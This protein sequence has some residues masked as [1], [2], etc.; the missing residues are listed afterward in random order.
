[1][2]QRYILNLAAN[3]A[4]IMANVKTRKIN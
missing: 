3:Q 1:M 2:Y 4:A